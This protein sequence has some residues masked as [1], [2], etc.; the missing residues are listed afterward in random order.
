MRMGPHMM[1]PGDAEAVKGRK[2]D[3]TSMARVWVFASPYKTAI[4]GFLLSIIFAS[5]VGLVPPFVFR[6][7]IDDAIP[8]DNRGRIWFLAMLAVGAALFDAFLAITQRWYSA[9]IGEGLIY[10]LRVSLF[11]KVQRMPVAFFT[12]TQTVS[13]I[14]RLNNDVVGAQSA[15]TST[16][17]SVVSNVVVLV[18]TL[19]AM[20]A[21]EWRLTLLSLVVLPIFVIPAKRVGQRLQ[22]IAR[23]QMDLNA[24]MN[25]QMNER[26]NVSGAL[27][28]KL[29][30]R[31]QG[32]VDAFSGR[33]ARVRDIGILSALYGRVF[34]VALGLVGALGAVAIYGIGA[35]LVVSGDISDGTLVALATLVGRVYQPLTGL[36]NA[37]VDLLTSFV[38]FDRVFEVLDA[39][40]SI[41]DKP[42]AIDLV[43]PRGRI[44][45]DHVTFRYPPA[46]E[47]SVPSLEMPGAPSGDP[48]VDVLHDISLVIEPGETI[49][50]VGSSGS[51]KS[52]LASLMPRLYDVTS[53]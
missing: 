7:I 44:E 35:Q 16:L 25:T 39:P 50:I 19:G 31:H 17:G 9:R 42:G 28:V 1:M 12:R 34:F 52:T 48:D 24:Q 33:A 2:I 49:A 5:A 26:F 22:I 14:S 27:L 15:V 53:G 6:A 36:T 45:F 30:G 10:D 20:F 37:R 51:G 4:I 18:M 23:E 3:R 11:D 29:F 13:L 8:S 21:L 43:N 40:M 46:R 47:V 41:V 38:S 32:E